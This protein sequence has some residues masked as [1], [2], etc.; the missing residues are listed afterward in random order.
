ME[1]DEVTEAAQGLPSE[2]HQWGAHGSVQPFPFSLS[3][4]HHRDHL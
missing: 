3:I 2:Q 4:P 1:T